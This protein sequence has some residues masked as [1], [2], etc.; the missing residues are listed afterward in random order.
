MNIPEEMF[1]VFL[2]NGAKKKYKKDTTIYMQEDTSD[3][4]YL[5]AKGR[6]RAY[7]LSSEGKEITF[8]VLQKGRIF[9]ESSFFQNI[10]RPATIQAVTNVELIV[11]QQNDLYEALHQNS[12]LA[13]LL[14]KM[15]TQVSDHL[16]LLVKRAYFYDRYAKVASLLLELTNKDDPASG[17]IDHIIPYT[18]SD[19]A[20]STGLA[21]VTVT[22]ILKEFE[23]QGY[24][25]QSYGKIFVKKPEDLKR[26]V[27]L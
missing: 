13:I 22:K 26:Y 8:E 9:G 6:V 20:E 17:I 2:A 10:S 23:T 7:S 5:V 24:I 16:A 4:L 15:Q 18:H 12:D 25:L 3:T 1:P 27:P 14:L 19:I 21:R 11:C